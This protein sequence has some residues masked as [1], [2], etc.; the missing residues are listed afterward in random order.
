M[1]SVPRSRSHPGSS[2]PGVCF[3][4]NLQMCSPP[5]RWCPLWRRRRL[6]SRRSPQWPRCTKPPGLL[7]VGSRFQTCF[8]LHKFLDSFFPLADPNCLISSERPDW[9]SA[10]LTGSSG[11][12]RT[13]SACRADGS[14]NPPLFPLTH[15]QHV[16]HHN[17]L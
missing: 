5:H 15:L 7:W 6:C 13:S 12:S 1:K 3:Q 9:R 17:A 2:L 4:M 8:G 16:A 14:A 11:S 10:G